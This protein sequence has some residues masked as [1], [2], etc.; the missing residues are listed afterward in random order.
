MKR[1]RQLEITETLN[2]RDKTYH[3]CSKLVDILLDITECCYLHLQDK[4][5]EDIDQR[6]WHE[7]MQLL[8]NLKSPFDI[9]NPRCSLGQEIY[10]TGDSKPDKFKIFLSLEM[11]DF[12]NSEG[13]WDL[14]I[15]PR[16]FAEAILK[17]KKY[18]ELG[19]DAPP[20]EEIESNYL[21]NKESYGPINNYIFGDIMESL[22]DQIYPYQEN[23]T[24]ID[25]PQ[26]LPVKV[27]IIGRSYSG[28]ST[29]G[30]FLNQKY[31]LEV[32]C[33]EE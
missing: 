16:N 24:D 22:I 2:E 26:Y 5:S 25:F 23:K 19:D 32:I 9:K 29:I 14:E 8:Q 31:G 13:Q 7:N 15:K 28:R 6:Y 27:T 4:D 12:T 21:A 3:K 30:N 20:I 18:S 10:L 1:E 17:D 33:I 11:Q